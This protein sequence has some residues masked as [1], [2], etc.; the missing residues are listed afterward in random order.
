MM[1]HRKN[2]AGLDIDLFTN[3]SVE[4]IYNMVKYFKRQRC[5]LECDSLFISLIL[6]ENKELNENHLFIIYNSSRS[7]DSVMYL[8]SKDAHK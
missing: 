3:I 6:R 1:S 8:Y 5:V 4:R 7:Q 2:I